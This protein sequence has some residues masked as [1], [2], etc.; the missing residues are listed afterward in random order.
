M[1]NLIE[2]AEKEAG[3]IAVGE[4]TRDVH[5]YDQK[6][7]VISLGKVVTRN[8]RNEQAQRHYFL[9]RKGEEGSEKMYKL[10]V[11]TS[12]FRFVDHTVA[13]DPFLNQGYAIKDTIISRGGMHMYAVLERPDASII[14]DPMNWDAQYWH[15]RSGSGMRLV[16]R[17][18]HESVVVFSSIR[19]GKGMTYRRGW[20]RLICSNG[21]VAEILNLG[22]MKF[23]HTN[24]NAG[25]VREKMG[26]LPG[27][28]EKNQFGPYIGNGHG[29]YRLG[30]LLDSLSA[31]LSDEEGDDEES[32]TNYVDERLLELPLFIRDEVRSFLA[33]PIWFRQM[34]AKQFY[35]MSEVERINGLDVVNAI[36][37]P[38]N[39]QRF[40]ETEPHSVLR[41]LVRANQMSTAASKLIGAFSL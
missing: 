23:N 6:G 19:P 26:L 21:L 3:M 1:T 4:R 25:S 27:L 13:L 31:V 24:W 39:L 12:H 35:A 17:E 32:T 8:Y 5:H 7:N 16:P 20:F 10:G 38:I 30:S 37:N 40:H 18:L 34:L 41:P 33:M 29:A 9:S 36:T 11:T 15:D 2:E 28:S 22:T 14:M